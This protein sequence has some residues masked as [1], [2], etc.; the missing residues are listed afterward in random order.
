MTFGLDKDFLYMT[1]GA[2]SIEEKF[3]K[4]DIIHESVK[5]REYKKVIEWKKIFLHH[6]SIDKGYVF[7]IH[8]ELSKLNNKPSFKKAKNLNW[9]FTKDFW[10][11]NKQDIQYQSSSDKCK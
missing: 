6:I 8:K 10:V 7:R 4:F 3:D 2:W 11:A 5:L 1:P 9:Y